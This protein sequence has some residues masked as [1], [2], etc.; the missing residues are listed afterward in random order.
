[1]DKFSRHTLGSAA[2]V[3]L[4]AMS[5]MASPTLRSHAREAI[6]SLRGNQASKTVLAS[7]RNNSE[8]MRLLA[9]LAGNVSFAPR[10]GAPVSYTHLTLPTN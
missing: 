8:K 2:V 3:L 9:P 7:E 1:M 5:F 4:S 6:A 10:A